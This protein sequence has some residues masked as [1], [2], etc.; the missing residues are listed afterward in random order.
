MSSCIGGCL[1]FNECPSICSG[2]HYSQRPNWP[3]ATGFSSCCVFLLFLDLCCVCISLS[4]FWRITCSLPPYV[5]AK[6]CLRTGTEITLSI[7]VG[8]G[9][10]HVRKAVSVLGAVA[11]RLQHTWLL[12]RAI[13][14]KCYS[15]YFFYRAS[16]NWRS[17]RD[18][19][20]TLWYFTTS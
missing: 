5:T 20:I 14:P 16:A 13:L 2:H 17:A 12:A 1:R 6:W 15:S 7:C 3:S 4:D 11:W 9:V 10:W 8:V 18:I 19:D